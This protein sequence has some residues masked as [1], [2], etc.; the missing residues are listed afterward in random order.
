[1]IIGL[2]VL[3]ANITTVLSL[4]LIFYFFLWYYIKPKVDVF[5]QDT[6][7]QVLK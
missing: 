4:C 1:M 2:Q 6:F 7:K 3:F 5:F